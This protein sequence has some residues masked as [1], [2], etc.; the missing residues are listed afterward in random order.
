MSLSAQRRAERFID[1]SSF[2]AVVSQRDDARHD[3]ARY[4]DALL[5]IAAMSDY[6][7]GNGDPQ[8][9]ARRVLEDKG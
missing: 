6:E 2:E 9:R 1:R 8:Q 3:C 7:A 4:R 5:D